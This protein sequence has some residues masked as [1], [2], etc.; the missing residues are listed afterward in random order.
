MKLYDISEPLAPE[1]AVF[2]GDTPFSREWIM[3]MEDGGSCN[4]S[5]I[6]MSAHCGTHTDAPLHF[7]SGGADMA[8]VD[9]EAYL[10]A[11]RVVEMKGEGEPAL[12][13]ADALTPGL[14]AGA[15]RILFRTR[16]RHDHR[17]F[18]PG[19]TAVGPAAARRL[20]EAGVRLVGIDSPSMDHATATELQ[21]H[22]VLC[23]GGVA[24]LE[25]LDLS[26]VSAGDYQLAALPL[27]I[28]GSDSSPVRAVLWR[29]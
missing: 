20:V 18:D 21:A 2:P 28:I 10:G 26:Q 27:K 14:L 16:S 7:D 29:D 23:A 15:E 24:I 17:V 8:A 13:P 3:R 4:V 9:L 1:T 25:N 6:R 5:T 11:C 12:V 19:F 22:Q